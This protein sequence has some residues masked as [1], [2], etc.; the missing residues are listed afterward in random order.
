MD[1]ESS[2]R[3]KYTTIVNKYPSFRDDVIKGCWKWLEGRREDDNAEGLWRV[4]NKLYNLKDF[5]VKHPGGKEWIYLTKVYF[6][7]CLCLVSFYFSIYSPLFRVETISRDAVT[8]PLINFQLTNS[9]IEVINKSAFTRFAYHREQILR[10]LLRVI[11]SDRYP[12]NCCK[13]SSSRKRMSLATTDSHTKR[14]DF[15]AC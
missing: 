10:K 11:T 8:Y 1:Q 12:H 14:M 2:A 6:A 9:A 4:H 5:A 13:N 7:F 15:I 3:V